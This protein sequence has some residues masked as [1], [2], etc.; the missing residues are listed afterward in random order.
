MQEIQQRKETEGRTWYVSTPRMES[1]HSN[2]PK[3]IRVFLRLQ[4][5]NLI[6]V[7][8]NKKPNE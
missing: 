4:C 3:K 7:S 2:K 6:G 5:G 8:L 1:Y